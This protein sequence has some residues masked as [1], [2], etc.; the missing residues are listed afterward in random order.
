MFENSE[1][2][3]FKDKDHLNYRAEFANRICK[4]LYDKSNGNIDKAIIDGE[5]LFNDLHEN[6]RNIYELVNSQIP[7]MTYYELKKYDADNWG[8]SDEEYTI[9]LEVT[10]A[11]CKDYYE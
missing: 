7:L 10:K 11:A 6:V 2:F 4:L 1:I 9:N 5:K 3:N 8:F